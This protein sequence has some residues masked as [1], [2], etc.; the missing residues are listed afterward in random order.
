MTQPKLLDGYYYQQGGGAWYV[1]R[2]GPWRPGEPDR[3]VAHCTT[4][5]NARLV[6]AALNMAA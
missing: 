3:I 4:E 6:C 2:D 5:A 1:T